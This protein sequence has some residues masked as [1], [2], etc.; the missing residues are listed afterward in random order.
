MTPNELISMTSNNLGDGGFVMMAR[1]EYIGFVN[2]VGH[3]IWFESKALHQL[4]Q[5]KMTEGER[6]FTIPD[7]D[8]IEF[9]ELQF[10]YKDTAQTNPEP[11]ILEDGVTAAHQ[12]EKP[13]HANIREGGGFWQNVGNWQKH[14]HLTPELRNGKYI[15][16]VPEPFIAGVVLHAHCIVH[17]T[18]YNWLDAAITDP[19]D[20][21]DLYEETLDSSLWE[22]LRNAYIEGTLWRAARRLWQFSKDRERRKTMDDAKELYYN[23]YLPNAIHFIHSLKADASALHVHPFALW[24]ERRI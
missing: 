13:V 4:R 10:R 12:Q 11:E 6:H 24:R 8:I 9:A 15:I 23:R 19:T 17:G 3:D 1:E 22:P 18:R 21:D 16:H 7:I 14:Y 5:Y 2:D 20:P